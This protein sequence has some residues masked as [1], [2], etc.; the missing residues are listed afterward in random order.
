MRQLT[1][2]NRA[3]QVGVAVALHESIVIMARQKVNGEARWL[4]AEAAA[5]PNVFG[6][7][8]NSPTMSNMLLNVA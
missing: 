2:Q 1:A 7:R 5:D 4:Q 3:L 8:S 6:R